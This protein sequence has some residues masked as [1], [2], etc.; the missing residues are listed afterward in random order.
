MMFYFFRI[1]L[2]ANANSI[3]TLYSLTHSLK[4]TRSLALVL[5]NLE[6]ANFIVSTFLWDLEYMAGRAIRRTRARAAHVLVFCLIFD[7]L[8]GV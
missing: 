8:V 6:R 2:K 3:F 5:F 1:S 7:A 4:H